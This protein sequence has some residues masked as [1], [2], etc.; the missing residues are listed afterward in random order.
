MQ[1]SRGHKPVRLEILLRQMAGG[2][3]FTEILDDGIGSIVDFRFELKPGGVTAIQGD[4]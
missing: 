2:R 1:V 3:A 4:P